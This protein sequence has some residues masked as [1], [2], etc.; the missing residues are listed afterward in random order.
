MLLV[1]GVQKSDLD[2][3][4][5]FI[6]G[7]YKILDTI[8]CVFVCVAQSCLTLWTPWDIAQQAPL[9]TEFSRQE[10]QSGLSFP[11]PGNLPNPE[12]KPRSP[13]LQADSLPS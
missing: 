7:Y 11:S 1:S 2:W 13:T 10:Y 12:I 6:I 4:F 5:F 9:S 8:S 3:G